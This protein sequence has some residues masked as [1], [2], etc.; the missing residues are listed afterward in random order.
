M[1]RFFLRLWAFTAIVHVLVFAALRE[2]LVRGGARWPTMGALAVTGVLL[3][4]FKQRV[5]LVRDDRPI[6]GARRVGELLYY[7]HWCGAVAAG[8]LFV[9]GGA[10]WAIAEGVAAIA[11]AA[12]AS[13]AVIPLTAGG[14]AL[15]CWIAGLA[16]GAYGVGVRARRPRVARVEVAVRGLAEGLDGYTIAQLSDL[17]VGSFVS[18]RRADRWVRAANAEA[19]DLVA[20][21]GDYVTSG[22]AFHEMIADVLAG[23]RARDGV[24]AV[25]GNHDYFGGGEPLASL[26]KERGVVLLRNAR[27]TVQRG[28]ASLEVAGVDDTWTR[29]A[30]VEATMRGWEGGRTLIALAHDPALFPDLARHGAALVLSG[31]THW[32]QIGVPFASAR[33]NIARRVFRFSAGLYRD[34]DAALYVSPGLGTTGPPVRFGSAPEITVLV[35]R[36]A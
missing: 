20:L 2:A 17:H 5:E 1:R 26:V 27:H 12:G 6:S 30:D 36:R 35:L 28:E 3:A 34:G 31:H 22:V 10:L 23:L 14:L 21:T 29:R 25:L 16:M 4:L 19:P 15:G 7:M 33:Y 24:I 13:G 9:L 18:R 8:L 11:R 32:G